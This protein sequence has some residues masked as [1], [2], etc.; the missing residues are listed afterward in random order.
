VRAKRVSV[1]ATSL[2]LAGVC[3]ALAGLI[4]ACGSTRVATRPGSAETPFQLASSAHPSSPS[5]SGLARRDA[6]LLLTLIRLPPGSEP[7]THE[8]SGDAGLLSSPGETI[9]GN[10]V[11][12]HRFY[13]V[14]EVPTS[15]DAFVL[16]H[17]PR[18]STRAGYGTGGVYGNTDQ[19]FV[20]YSWLPVKALF[21]N[22]LLV[23]S[24]AALPDDRS[25]V[26]VDAEVTW[27]PA[28]PAGDIIPTGAKVLTAVLS[29]GLNPGEAGHA[30]VTTTDPGKIEAIRDFI[31]RLGVF[32][33]G[34]RSCPADF[35]QYLTISFA[36]SPAAAP[37]D[38]VVADTSGCE[39]V[40]VQH[41]GRS[42]QPELWGLEPPLV[43]FVE[44]ELGF[45]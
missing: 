7:V 22:R 38:V 14:A 40:Q 1:L 34:A 23:I 18:G 43:P 17:R 44:G 8:P 6:A 45:S 12:L 41:L 35:G 29:A 11:D 24:I 27:L 2:V 3:G 16:S 28:K 42:V 15:V 9:G 19:W 5:R 39:A 4:G 13:V 37:F 32:P 31:N 10:L 26:R 33:P 25:G 21:D 20:S 36:A 30:P